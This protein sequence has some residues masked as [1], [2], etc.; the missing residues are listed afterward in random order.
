LYYLVLYI[1]RYGSLMLCVEVTRVG[2]RIGGG[3]REREAKGK[4][5]SLAR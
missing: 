3:G 2:G 4:V 1:V 5:K